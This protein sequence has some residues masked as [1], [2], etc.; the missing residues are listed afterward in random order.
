[1]KRK[2]LIGPGVALLLGTLFLGTA[3]ARELSEDEKQVV[4]KLKEVVEEAGRDGFELAYWPIVRK[5]PPKT[6]APLTLKLD[7]SIDYLFVG[8]C[9]ENCS[10]VNLSIKTLGGEVLQSEKD[11][12]S[13]ITFKPPEYTDYELNLNMATCTE[14]EGCVYGIGILAPKGTKVP[15]S[16]A[17]PEEIAQFEFCK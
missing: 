16:P 12:L 4:C 11:T 7:S 9:D 10:D 13:V 5:G 14:E 15:Y 2:H 6:N 1:M 3:I 8:Y 17:L